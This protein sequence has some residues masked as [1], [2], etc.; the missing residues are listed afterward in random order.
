MK[1]NLNGKL[2]VNNL[3]LQL[4]KLLQN[5]KHVTMIMFNVIYVIVNLMNK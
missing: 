2:K 4:A 5:N 3:E 1:K